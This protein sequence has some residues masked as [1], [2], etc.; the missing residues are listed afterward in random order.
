VEWEGAGTVESWTTPFD[1]D[2]LPEK[3]FLAVRTPDDRRALALLPDPAAAA[4]TV[5]EDIAGAKVTIHADGTAT[6]K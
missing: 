4:Q 6:L 1:R 2:G 3:A 5:Y